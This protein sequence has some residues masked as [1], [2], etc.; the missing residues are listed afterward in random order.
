MNVCEN[1]KRARG[2]EKEGNQ[3]KDENPSLAAG[4]VKFRRK[5]ATCGRIKNRA[6]PSRR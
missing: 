5:E 2:T 3:K 4:V 6:F 1:P